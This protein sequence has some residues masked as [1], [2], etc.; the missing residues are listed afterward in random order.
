MGPAE[1]AEVGSIASLLALRELD[2]DV[3][4]RIYEATRRQPSVRWNDHDTYTLKLLV[5][6]LGEQ[7]E[8]ISN[9]MP[10]R[11]EKQVCQLSMKL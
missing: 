10:N 8:V 3:S 7:Y 2:P 6:H 5:A 4:T 11:T 9:L 1:R